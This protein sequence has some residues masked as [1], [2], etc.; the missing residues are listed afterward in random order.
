MSH[1]IYLRSFLSVY[2][3]NSI[4]RAADAL[5]LTQPAV[6]RHIKVL[7]GRLGCRLFERLPRGLA[8]T[9]AANELERQVGSHLDAL[10]AVVGISGGKN[11]GLAGLIHV[12]STSGFTKLVLSGLASLPQYGIRLDLQSASPP[13]LLKALAERELDFAVTPARIPHKAIDYDLLYEGPLMLV[14]APRWR[15]RLPKSAVPKGLPLIDIQGPLPVLAGFWRAAFGSNPDLPS[16]TVPDYQAAL[17]AAAAGTGLAVVPECLCADMLQTGQLISQNIRAK[18][19]VSI[20]VARSKG[21]IA[22][23]RVRVSHQLLTD[24]ARGW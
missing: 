17:D 6:S 11:E 12:G 10:E 2:R 13:A 15:E 23:D 5:H 7:E 20:Y 1:L 16:A 21:N 22:V 18:S 4:S 8:S 24:A 3:H 19:Q 14:C 9:P